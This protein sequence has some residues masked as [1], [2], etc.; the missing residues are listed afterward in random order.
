MGGWI[1]RAKVSLDFDNAADYELT[2]LLP[3]ENFAQQIRTNQAR[4][5]IIEGAGEGNAFGL[6]TDALATAYHSRA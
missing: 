5:A 3:N 1:I 4:V 6:R 2:A